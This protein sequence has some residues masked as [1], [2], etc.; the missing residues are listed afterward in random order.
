M[1]AVKRGPDRMKLKDLHVKIRCQG[2]P[3]EN[4]A[5]WK[6]L[7]KLWILAVAL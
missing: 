5:G 6:S 7:C 4:T 1:Q 2:T 3:G